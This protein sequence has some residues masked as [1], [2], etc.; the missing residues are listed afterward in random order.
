MHAASMAILIP[1]VAII[2]VFS[3]PIVAIIMAIGIPAFMQLK[4]KDTMRK[5]VEDVIEL[6]GEAR[7]RAVLDGAIVEVRIRPSDRTLF[8]DIRFSISQARR[9][10]PRICQRRGSPDTE[11]SSSLLSKGQS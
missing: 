4:D 5:A 2:M 3:I 8:L 7:A 1:V 9:N 11:H 6:C 10:Q